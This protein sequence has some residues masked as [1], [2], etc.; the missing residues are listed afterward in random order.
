MYCY[1]LFK[2]PRVLKRILNSY[3]YS[4]LKKLIVVFFKNL[5]S[6]KRVLSD[7]SY[8]MLKNLISYLENNENIED[9]F[10]IFVL[11]SYNCTFGFFYREFLSFCYGLQLAGQCPSTFA[12]LVFF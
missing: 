7:R 2:N 12:N 11:L 6:L 5:L 10:W 8:F 3:D 9:L 1:Y 4:A